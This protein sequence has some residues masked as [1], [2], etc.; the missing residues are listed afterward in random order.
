MKTWRILLAT[1]AL[2][3]TFA[4]GC[5]TTP[6]AP[7][8]PRVDGFKF[9][10]STFKMGDSVELSLDYKN[11]RGGLKKSRIVLEFQ[12]SLPNHTRKASAFAEAISMLADGTEHGTFRTT[13]RITPTDSPPFDIW[14]FV[15]V[16]DAEGRRSNE[17]VG[18]VSYKP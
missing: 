2:V 16:V 10:P 7:D 12:G 1:L 14:Y 15:R 11:I 3:V 9:T 6:S 18:K 8:A 17:A 13:F 5:A 4:A